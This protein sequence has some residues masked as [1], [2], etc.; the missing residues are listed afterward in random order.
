MFTKYSVLDPK[1]DVASDFNGGSKE[2]DTPLS[3]AD[4]VLDSLLYLGVNSLHW[5]I[6]L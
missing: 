2:R 5:L 1:Q 6:T 3:S 4:L